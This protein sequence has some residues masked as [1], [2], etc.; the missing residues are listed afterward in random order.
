MPS[1]FNNRI[2]Y[3][4]PSPGQCNWD[5]DVERNNAINASLLPPGLDGNFVTSGGLTSDGGGLTVDITEAIVTVAGSEFTVVAATYDLVGATVEAELINFIWIDSSGV[6]HVTQEEPDETMVLLSIIDAD[7]TSVLRIIDGRQMGILEDESIILGKNRVINGSMKVDQW[8]MGASVVIGSS[9]KFIV[10]RAYAINTTLTG[11]LTGQQ[12]T[13]GSDKSCKTTATVAISD[14]TSTKEVQAFSK[15]IESQN[16]YDLNGE[17][18]TISFKIET[19][20]DGNL[21]VSISNSD[22]SKSYVVDYAV[23][24]GI[25]DVTI[26]IPLEAATILTNN[27]LIGLQITV[28][29]NNEGTYQ[30]AATG[31]WVLGFFGC[32]NLSTQW[33]KITGNFINIT[34]FQLEKGDEKTPFEQLF[35]D[36]ILGSCQRYYLYIEQWPMTSPRT[37]SSQYLGFQFPVTMRTAP[38]G[39]VGA[40]TDVDGT[41]ASWSSFSLKEYGITRVNFTIPTAVTSR[42]L[43]DDIKINAE[44]I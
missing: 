22:I 20:W 21:P 7:I 33:T 40:T 38:T 39:L 25:N 8:N 12:S 44:L 2:L 18:I 37:A 6:A 34:D 5:K 15:R 19:N 11:T 10:D 4:N 32:S 14:L 16:I 27:N 31:S 43:F 26:T 9:A 28:G 23:L 13:I 41:G 17:D 24:S 30:T 35:I 3:S 1:T 36:D 42:F 29:F